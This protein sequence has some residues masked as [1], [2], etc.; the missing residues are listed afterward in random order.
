M[1]EARS[2]KTKESPKKL[3]A[4]DHLDR[5]RSAAIGLARATLVGHARDYHGRSVVAKLSQNQRKRP[6]TLKDDLVIL[7]IPKH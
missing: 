2:N 1:A 7:D 6:K 4:R 5:P 3:R